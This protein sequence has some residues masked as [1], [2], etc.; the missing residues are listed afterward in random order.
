M[1]ADGVGP[2]FTCSKL[3]LGAQRAGANVDLMVN[4]LR[5]SNQ[6]PRSHAI[7]PGPLA[8][9]P[10]KWVSGPASSALEAW[11]LNRIE[12][13]DLAWLWPSVSL[14][15][16]EKLA[17]RGIPIL[18]EGINTRMASAKRILDAAY[19]AIGARPDHG[20]SD[21]RVAEEEQ[22]IALA[23]TIFAPSPAVEAALAGSPLEN[24]FVATSYGVEIGNAPER[25]APEHDRDQPVTFLFC[26]YACVR[27]GAHHL[28]NVWKHMPED[29]RLRLV[30]R[31]EPL[32]SARYAE[33][34]SSDRVEVVGFTRNVSPHY[35]TA[36]AF[37]FP[38]LEEG[39][40]LVTYEA[41]LRGLPIIASAPGAGRIGAERGSATIIDPSD[42]EMLLDRL[43][44]FY[45][46]RD[47]RIEDGRRAM[48]EVSDFD[49]DKV[50]AKRLPALE[51]FLSRRPE[52]AEIPAPATL[53]AIVKGSGPVV[54][55]VL[56]AY[57]RADTILP[58]IQSVLRQAYE[59]FELLVV[60]D[61]SSDDTMDVVRGIADRRI[62]LM[63][64]PHNMGPSGARNV[65]IREARAEWVA[66]QDSDD[67]WLPEKLERKLVRLSTAPA[68]CVAV[69]C[70]MVIVGSVAPK[71]AR[72]GVQYIPRSSTKLV[73]GHMRTALFTSSLISTQ[74]LMA[75]KAD[76][77][78]V[79]GFDESLQALV[80]WDLV[81]RLSKRGP[82][83]FVD[84]PLVLQRFSDNSITRDQ[85]RRTRARARIL[86]KYH[87]EM[88]DVPELLSRQYRILASECHRLGAHEDARLAINR[89]RRLQP[90][91][92]GLLAR[93][94]YHGTSAALWPSER[95][96]P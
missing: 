23:R 85:L 27:K 68:D 70:G 75:R 16:H 42:E 30:G 1:A 91:D 93:S 18:I 9:L 65:G 84:E 35:A 76:I 83:A 45:S 94:I 19:D 4:R 10:Y 40:P 53:P 61:G 86:D 89:A 74:M 71:T 41:A 14:A 48:I 56:P 52:P 92:L 21:A 87:D 79:G 26:G 39:D 8:H 88:L 25:P 47:R 3:V 46:D 28:L 77:D 50:A 81:L 72:T 59:N 17:E 69:Y 12:P 2:S 32:I 96:D 37:V 95:L 66:F 36:D 15:T 49:W 24:R 5:N 67:E 22:K 82:F 78:A 34:L 58:S 20:I 63:A 64:T 11:Y 43:M 55:V 6:V 29:A 44:A 38:S 57:N 54:S 33:M 80:D 73:E 31:I 60:D 90:R 51:N 62:R 7:L 13:G